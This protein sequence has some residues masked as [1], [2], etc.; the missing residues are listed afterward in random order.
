MSKMVKVHDVNQATLRLFEV[1]D[2][3]TIPSNIYHVFD[4]DS[5]LDTFAAEIEAIWDKE[6]FFRMEAKQKT[7][8]G[9]LINVIV[10]LPVPKTL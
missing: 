3:E 4:E 1:D 5:S 9:E 10:S 8:K 6:A 2:V 7:Q